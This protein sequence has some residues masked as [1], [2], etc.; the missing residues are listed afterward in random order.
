MNKAFNIGNFLV[1]T[2]NLCAY[3]HFAPAKIIINVIYNCES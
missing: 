2:D 3:V 1:V